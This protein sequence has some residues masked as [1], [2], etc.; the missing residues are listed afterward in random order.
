MTEVKDVESHLKSM[1]GES[2]YQ[3]VYQYLIENQADFEEDCKLEDADHLNNSKILKSREKRFRKNAEMIK[4]GF[5]LE[6]PEYKKFS[7]H[8]KEIFELYRHTLKADDIKSLSEG[9]LFSES[10]VNL[11]FKILEKMN[12]VLLTA[13]QF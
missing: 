6:M 9:T 7:P 11:Y 10:F 1:F 3:L 5:K 13:Q 4:K 8:V 2:F 12:L